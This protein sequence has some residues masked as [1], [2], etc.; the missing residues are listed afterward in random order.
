MQRLLVTPF[1]DADHM[2]GFVYDVTTGSINEV[3]LD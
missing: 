1:V 3:T 2:R